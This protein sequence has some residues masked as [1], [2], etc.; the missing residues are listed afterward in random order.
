MSK[1]LWNIFLHFV[2]HLHIYDFLSHINFLSSF[3]QG[4][5][6]VYF[7]DSEFLG[8]IRYQGYGIVDF[9][10]SLGGLLGIMIGASVLSIIELFY[11]FTLRMIIDINR[12][13]DLKHNEDAHVVIVKEYGI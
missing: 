2:E 7:R 1:F 12:Y 10:S 13:L 6:F 3:F 8:I 11:F 4:E 9:L 5:V